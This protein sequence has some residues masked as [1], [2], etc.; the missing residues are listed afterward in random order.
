MKEE[1]WRH[2]SENEKEG[3]EEWNNENES[4]RSSDYGRR[5]SRME[6]K[7]SSTNKQ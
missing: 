6:Q 4:E 3:K 2:K 7:N 1:K 5:R